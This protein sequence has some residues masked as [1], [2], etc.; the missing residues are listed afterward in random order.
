MLQIKNQQRNQKEKVIKQK[1]VQ[2]THLLNL[3]IE[4]KWRMLLLNN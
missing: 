1:E 3:L 4:T 2:R